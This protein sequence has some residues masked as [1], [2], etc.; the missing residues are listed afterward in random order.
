MKHDSSRRPAVPRATHGPSTIGVPPRSHGPHRGASAHLAGH[1]ASGLRSRRARRCSPA[2]PSAPASTCMAPRATCGPQQGLKCHASAE[3]VG[4]QQ[5]GDRRV[6]TAHPA[7]TPT[8][9]A[10][11]WHLKGKEIAAPP[12]HPTTQERGCEGEA[13][14]SLVCSSEKFS[15]ITAMK[16]FSITSEPTCVRVRGRAVRLIQRGGRVGSAWLASQCGARCD[17]LVLVLVA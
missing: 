8:L 3:A 5:G 9:S 15:R 12:S 14:A 10:K 11:A 7:V 2:G 4:R 16:R 6:Q 17:V 13:R 1:A